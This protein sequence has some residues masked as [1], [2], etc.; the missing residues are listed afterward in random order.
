MHVSLFVVLLIISLIHFVFAAASYSTGRYNL[1][2]V[3]YSAAAGLAFCV[4]AVLVT[5]T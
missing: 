5:S 3:S 2:A 1:F 4:L